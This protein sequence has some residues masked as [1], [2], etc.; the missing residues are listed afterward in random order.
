MW[1]RRW[2]PEDLGVGFLHGGVG[3]IKQAQPIPGLLELRE[4]EG[5]LEGCLLVVLR[6]WRQCRL[7]QLACQKGSDVP[8]TETVMFV[9]LS[10]IVGE[11]A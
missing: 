9:V 7:L 8:T 11:A 10:V 6:W 4:L 5:N 1:W 2:W 3:E